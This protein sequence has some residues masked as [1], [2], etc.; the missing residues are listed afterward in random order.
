VPFVLGLAGFFKAAPVPDPQHTTGRLSPCSC[1][2]ALMKRKHVCRARM[3][4]T[5]RSGT[6]SV[7]LYTSGSCILLVQ[8][9]LQ[10]RFEHGFI[11]APF[12]LLLGI[13][14]SLAFVEQAWQRR[15]SIGVQPVGLDG[16]FKFVFTADRP[17]EI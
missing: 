5:S 11:A 1:G 12:N 6:L 4:P 15:L 2:A 9:S 8:A 17:N 10:S 3:A 7:L 14:G 13:N 16:Y